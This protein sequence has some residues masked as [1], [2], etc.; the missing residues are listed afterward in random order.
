M[1]SFLIQTRSRLV[2]GYSHIGEHWTNSSNLNLFSLHSNIH[3]TNYNMLNQWP[4]TQQ[5]WKTVMAS[6][7]RSSRARNFFRKPKILPWLWYV[8]PRWVR[9]RQDSP[10]LSTPSPLN[11]LPSP[12]KA[13]TT[14]TSCLPRP[15][16]ENAC[17]EPL[18]HPNLQ[19]DPT[20][21]RCIVVDMG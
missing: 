2:N 4:V 10:P 6:D 18:Q 12:Q 14:Q 13:Q 5:Y 20:G 21:L 16:V 19:E 7:V 9:D 11:R 8:D 15:E 17:H 1:F 3:T